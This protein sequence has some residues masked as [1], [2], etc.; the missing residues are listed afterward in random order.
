MTAHAATRWAVRQAEPSGTLRD[1]WGPTHPVS[2][3]TRRFA[4]YPRILA[5]TIPPTSISLEQCRNYYYPESSRSP[6]R[7][8][9]CAAFPSLRHRRPENQWGFCCVE[10][11]GAFAPER[12]RKISS[13]REGKHATF[14]ASLVALTA[15][16]WHSRAKRS[17]ECVPRAIHSCARERHAPGKLGRHRRRPGIGP[18]SVRDRQ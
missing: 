8:S 18:G 16:R 3:S 11:A 5:P 14:V 10:K 2:L 1:C 12:S 9:C 4:S 15:D 13:A 6:T 7:P 17:I